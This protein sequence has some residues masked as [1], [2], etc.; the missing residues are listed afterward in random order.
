MNNICVSFSLQIL[1]S[2]VWVTFALLISSSIWNHCFSFQMRNESRLQ[3]VVFQLANKLL[4][5]QIVWAASIST[6]PGRFC[7]KVLFSVILVNLIFP[8]KKKEKKADYSGNRERSDNAPI[9]ISRASAIHLNFKTSQFSW[10]GISVPVPPWNHGKWQSEAKQNK[11]NN[12][13]K[14]KIKSNKTQKKIIG[15]DRESKTV[16]IY[17]LLFSTLETQLN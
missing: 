8:K 7:L 16:V 11:A 15:I 4:F 3:A 10:F 17:S 2:G 1:R 14:K 13:N 9:N 5:C 12:N 6:Y